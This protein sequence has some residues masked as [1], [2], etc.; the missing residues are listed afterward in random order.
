MARDLTPE[1]AAEALSAGDDHYRAFV[2]PP[3]RY[4]LIGASQFSL[5]FLL[6][7]RENHRLLDF[8]CGSLRLG[9][10]AIPYL[11]EDRYFGV[12]PEAWL[13]QEGFARELGEGARDLK[14]PRFDHNRD[15]RVDMF[16]T[17]FDFIVAQSV[18][19]H[20][21]P[22]MARMALENFRP[23]LEDGGLIV[24]NWLLGE[25][26]AGDEAPQWV[27]PGCVPYRHDG[28]LDLAAEV[29]LAGRRVEWFHPGLSWFVLAHSEDCLPESAALEALALAPRSHPVFP[30]STPEG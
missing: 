12:E 3:G 26:S 21:N 29:G 23:A 15:C 30:S 18:F 6:G 10:M 2:G 20:M 9:R 22:A 16:G 4:D 27:Y 11:R 25:P 1:T 13:V 17:R 24:L 7:L 28:V 19:S 8:G 14:R 5:L